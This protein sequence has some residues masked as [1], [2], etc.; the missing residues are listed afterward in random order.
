MDPYS[1]PGAPAALPV[2]SPARIGVRY[3]ATILFILAILSACA[4]PV[5]IASAIFEQNKEG[6][7]AVD[8]FFDGLTREETRKSEA[9]RS[10]ERFGELLA[11]VVAFGFYA[12]SLPIQLVGFYRMRQGRSYTLS[13]VATVLACIPCYST[14]CGVMLPFGIW[15]LIKLNQGDVKSTFV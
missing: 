6:P 8:S 12:L 11:K 1:S 7:S 14:C 9:Y 15:G 5:F 10:G 13:V 4:F 3:P 2:L